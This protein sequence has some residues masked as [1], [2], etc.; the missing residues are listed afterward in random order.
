MTQSRVTRGL[1][2]ELSVGRGYARA[3][4]RPGG[5]L[6][7]RRAKAPPTCQTSRSRVRHEDVRA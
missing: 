6:M 4:E 3:Y 2:H 7:L 5:E 1:S